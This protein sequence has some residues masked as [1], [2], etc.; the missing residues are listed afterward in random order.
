MTRHAVTLGI[1]KLINDPAPIRRK[2]VAVLSHHAAVTHALRRTVDCIADL[3]CRLVRIFGPEH[4]FWAVAQDME[5]AAA[6]VDIPT[7]VEIV[8]LYHEYP[9]LP[10]NTGAAGMRRWKSELARAKAKLS[11][12]DEQLRDVDVLVVDLQDVGSRYY[13]F[14]NTMANCMAV[15]KRTGTKVLVLDRPNPINGVDVE[16]NFFD[17]RRWHSFVGQFNI[18]PR[19]GMTIG[20]LARYYASEYEGYD[21]DLEV[22]EMSGWKRKYWWDETDLPWVPP[23]PNMPTIDTATVYPGLC[24]IEATN[25]SE[26]RGTT[27]PFELFGA[28]RIDAFALAERLNAF[29][30]P[31]VGFRAQYFKPT[32]Q[33]RSKEGVCGGVQV[34]VY[35]RTN[36]QPYLTGIIT[37]KVLYDIGREGMFDFGWRSEAYEY[38][39]TDDRHALEQL[40]GTS[41]FRLALESN[42][43]DLL[44]DWIEGWAEDEKRFRSE[45]NASLL[46]S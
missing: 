36:F 34:H 10:A 41:R 24:L 35:D 16:G 46:Y 37:M 29:E 15:A 3:P 22:I 45:R 33:K 38:E 31:G 5:G 43:G 8:S 18:L 42:N 17:D 25:V 39:P 7:G 2:R 1:E 32:F 28:P 44:G 20:E 4:G 6:S 12:S 9:K 13:T 27:I 14:V 23:S 30:L 40:V 21:C 19:H 11:P 26:G